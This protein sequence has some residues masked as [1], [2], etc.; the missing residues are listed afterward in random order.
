MENLP[1]L[2]SRNIYSVCLVRV[3][4]KLYQ[5]QEDHAIWFVSMFA[6]DQV[7]LDMNYESG[8][9]IEQRIFIHLKVVYIVIFI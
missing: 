8:K 6:K 1:L 7:W 3:Y 9:K 4:F 5:S 2:F